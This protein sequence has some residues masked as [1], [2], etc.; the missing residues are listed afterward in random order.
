MAVPNIILD[1]DLDKPTRLRLALTGGSGMDTEAREVTIKDV[2]SRWPMLED[3]GC[4][5]VDVL[6]YAN[7]KIEMSDEVF[8]RLMTSLNS[9]L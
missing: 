3:S 2:Q 8:T 9:Y 1:G 6:K 7:N 5:A 4:F